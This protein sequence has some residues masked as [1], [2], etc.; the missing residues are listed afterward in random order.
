MVG[1]LE[2]ETRAGRATP[3][4][5]RANRKSLHGPKKELV[6][7]AT[8]TALA[9]A[10]GISRS[11]L[12]YTSKKE[13]RDWELKAQIEEVLRAHPAYGSRNVA[14]ELGRNR[15]PVRRVM[16]KFGIK[17]YRRR[18]RK[19]R[20]TKNISVI[21][22]NIL[23]TTIPAYPHHVWAADFTELSWHDMTVYVATVIDLFTR[24][25]VGVAVSLRKGAPLTM[26]ALW[27]ALLHYPHSIIFHSDNGSEYDAAAFKNILTD[28]S[29][30]I[31]RSYPGCPWENGY[32]ES[33]YGK[34]KLDLG[35]PNRFRSLGELVTEIYHTIW[36][37]NTTRIH[38]A[39]KM[40]PRT[41]AKRFAQDIIEIKSVS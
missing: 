37:Y 7:D 39:L 19:W 13:K 36:T 23:L 22:A 9:T 20:K 21:Y 32:Q 38:S 25:I 29:I 15:K 18:G 12:Y 10:L 41:F 5:R 30:C 4:C 26:Q 16:R 24:E 11:A 34:F 17:P 33:F 28:F 27:H 6:R 3:H 8:K 1:V 31:S 35:D 40:P 2:T 14:I